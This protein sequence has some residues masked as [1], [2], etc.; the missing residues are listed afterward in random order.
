M[1]TKS[2]IGDSS[3]RGFGDRT[4][5]AAAGLTAI[6][7]VWSLVNP[8]SLTTTLWRWVY[9]F[10]G[11]FSWFTIILPFAFL[12]ICLYVGLGKYGNYKFGGC[13]ARP[14]FSTFS[15][16]GMLFTAG[17]GV[18]LVNFGVAEPMS[19]YLTSP[20][21]IKG[22]FDPPQAA[23]NAL[24]MSMFIWGLT[25]WSIYTIS[26][27]VVGYFTYSRGSKF[28]PGSPI[29]DGFADKPWSKPLSKVANISAAGA[30]AL[31]ISASIG[32]GV[33]QVRNGIEAVTGL[34]F[35]GM[36]FSV[37]ILVALFL[38]YTAFAILPVGKGMKKLGDAN[39]CIAIGLLLFVFAI[40]PTRYFMSLIVQ[41]LSGTVL[42]MIPISMRT[43]PFIEKKWFNDWPLTTMIWWISWTPFMGVFIAR[44]S[45]GRSLRQFM[46]ASILTPTLFLVA[47]FSVFGG[48]G[49]MDTILG[50]GK[51]A[52]YIINNPDDVYLSFIMVLQALPFFKIT[53]VIFIL[54]I[55]VFLSTTATSAAISL[56]MITSNGAENAP[57]LK[58]LTWSVIMATVAF[59]NVA[60]GTLSGVRAVAVSL[61]IPYIFFLLLQVSGVMRAMRS[62]YRK[63]LMK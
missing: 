2:G 7:S 43:F 56:S 28:L 14:E 45:K 24:N 46:L 30:A 10:H 12:C 50:S 4:F 19:H 51:I 9:K 53:G 34:K 3:S 31:T 59:A 15:W 39:V 27:L 61:A 57:P 60:T 54:L 47:W 63:G 52:D 20:L 49:L 58:T 44:I 17:I 38:I 18:G 29:A 25:A 6:F 55:V 32:M 22:G 16:L 37:V 11:A 41:T 21:G 23:Q 5:W 35:S 40:G 13:D 33:F 1:T 26:G 8:T 36:T 62:D 42:D 48:Y